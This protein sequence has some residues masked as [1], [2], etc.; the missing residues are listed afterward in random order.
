M[1]VFLL[2]TLS[3]I[4]ATMVLF[5]LVWRQ[6]P[7]K[8]INRL[9]GYRTDWSMKSHE[10]WDFAHKYCAA[11]WLWTGIPIWVISIVAWSIGLR[12][13]Y[14]TLTRVA[15]AL[16]LVQCICLA[17]PILPTEIA[18]RRRFDTDGKGKTI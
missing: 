15:T 1:T 18:L 7:P 11:L 3:L 16:T 10:T 17:L 14:S 6:N 2:I 13:G 4:P 9:Y 5:G 8:A 12:C